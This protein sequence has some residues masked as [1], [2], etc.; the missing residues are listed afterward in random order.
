MQ[1]IIPMLME[2]AAECYVSR[3]AGLV[4]LLLGIGPTVSQPLL[5]KS[6]SSLSF[7]GKFCQYMCFSTCVY[8][9]TQTKIAIH[10]AHGISLIKSDTC[11]YMEFLMWNKC[12]DMFY[13]HMIQV[14]CMMCEE[15]IKWG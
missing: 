13:C 11:N 7:H 3:V 14:G 6:C 4:P 1:F 2:L 9:I 10:Y 12:S 15:V 5:S 8:R